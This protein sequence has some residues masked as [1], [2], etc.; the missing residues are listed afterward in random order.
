MTRT[1]HLFLVKKIAKAMIFFRPSLVGSASNMGVIA[2]H[3]GDSHCVAL[4]LDGRTFAWG[5]NQSCQVT[6]P[7]SDDTQHPQ[8]ISAPISGPKALSVA[9]GSDYSVYL[10]HSGTLI[11]R[12]MV[13]SNK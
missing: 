1:I 2:V 11:W 3:C 10:T 8:V 5:L 6:G 4:C 9:A 12:G 7:N 13:D